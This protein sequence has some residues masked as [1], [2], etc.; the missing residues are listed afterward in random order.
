MTGYTTT[1]LLF[2]GKKTSVEEEEAITS[3]AP[4]GQFVR[5]PAG[6]VGSPESFKGSVY[7]GTFEWVKDEVL[8]GFCQRMPLDGTDV[9]LYLR[10][11]GATVPT[12]RIF[13]HELVGAAADQD[14]AAEPTGE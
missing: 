3:P 6:T 1:A 13:Q 10:G 9:V 8:L 7:A 5:L 2:V 11:E 12:V 14:D 4:G